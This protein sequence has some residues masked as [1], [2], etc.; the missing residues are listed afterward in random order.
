MQC[1]EEL[2]GLGRAWFDPGFPTTSGFPGLRILTTRNLLDDTFN[3]SKI[4]LEGDSDIDG[5]L[6]QVFL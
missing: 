2:I 4:Y 5:D 3:N 6:S 1:A